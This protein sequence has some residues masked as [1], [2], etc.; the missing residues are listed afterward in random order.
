MCMKIG[1]DVERTCGMD[2]AIQLGGWAMRAAISKD[3]RKKSVKHV[4]QSN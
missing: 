4:K 2:T 1:L 3:K